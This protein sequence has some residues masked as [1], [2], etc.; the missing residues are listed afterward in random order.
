[1]LFS[2]ILD[3]HFRLTVIW[4]IQWSIFFVC[5]GLLF[6]YIQIVPLL[7]C[8]SLLPQSLSDQV[9]LLRPFPHLDLV[10]L[11]LFRRLLL[12]FSHSHTALQT[13]SSM[14]V[15]KSPRLIT[16]GTLLQLAFF[17][18]SRVD[19]F[20]PLFLCRPQPLQNDLRDHWVHVLVQLRGLLALCLPRLFAG[21]LV[22][23]VLLGCRWSRQK[24]FE[25]LEF[26]ERI[27][28]R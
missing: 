24:V 10:L 17:L 18:Q 13:H 1:M 8:F 26:R 20:G 15:V 14:P 9:G 7:G 19:P 5:I 22:V 12:L 16:K 4:S 3:N 25:F 2:V 6:N 23:A 28:Q 21:R 27:Y 11:R